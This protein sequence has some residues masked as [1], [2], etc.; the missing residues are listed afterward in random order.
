MARR[1]FDAD[2]SI[3]VDDLGMSHGVLEIMRQAGLVSLGQNELLEWHA[4]TQP[5][6]VE[7]DS[8][9]LV[10]SPISILD[11]PIF[12]SYT[13][14]HKIDLVLEL[15]RKHWDW[16]FDRC[17]FDGSEFVFD[18]MM[19]TRSKLYFVALLLWDDLTR[20]GVTRVDSQML[21]NYYRIIVENK[22]RNV[23]LA[24]PADEHASLTDA[25][26]VAILNGKSV[27]DVL[28]IEGE[29][30]G[31]LAVEDGYCSDDELP[32]G[33]LE[34]EPEPPEL[35]VPS[36]VGMLPVVALSLGPRSYLGW[37][38]HHSLSFGARVG[39]DRY[40]IKCASHADCFKERATHLEPTLSAV[41]GFL[42][43]WAEEGPTRTREDHVDKHAPRPDGTDAKIA[44]LEAAYI[45]LRP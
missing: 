18:V 12:A 17:Q 36:V 23:L 27:E 44:E 6:T 39:R 25:Q 29:A 26:L 32:A 43:A 31:L 4:Y 37:T 10:V 45:E 16:T 8:S 5:E 24:L 38:I 1:A 7:F 19:V 41:F 11:A 13:A 33:A 40:W 2:S 20:A 3:P 35:F 30:G 28:A 42:I 22:G 9:R 14:S 34:P 21:H 15:V